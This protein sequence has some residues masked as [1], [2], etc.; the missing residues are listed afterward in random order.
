MEP[1][2]ITCLLRI[3]LDL[4]LQNYIKLLHLDIGIIK[5]IADLLKVVSRIGFKVASKIIVIG[6][7]HAVTM[8]ACTIMDHPC[9]LIIHKVSL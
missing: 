6:L 7:E 8:E 4:M 9:W 2:I 1:I 3:N 5:G